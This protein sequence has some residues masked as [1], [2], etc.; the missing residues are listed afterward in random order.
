MLGG[1]GKRRGWREGVG[2]SEEGDQGAVPGWREDASVSYNDAEGF[3]E[4]PC[5][6]VEAVPRRDI[7]IRTVTYTKKNKK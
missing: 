7:G 2:I 4:Y 5:E 6:G 1:A 3:R